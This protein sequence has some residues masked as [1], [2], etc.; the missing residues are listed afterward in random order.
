MK[1]QEFKEL[2]LQR[3]VGIETSAAIL[4]NIFN[5]RPNPGECLSVYASRLVTSL[6]TKWKTANI[7]EIAVSVVLVHA[8]QMDKR[9]KS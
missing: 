2:F 5:G 9:P 4:M 3:F 7:E 6:L 1:C 8:S